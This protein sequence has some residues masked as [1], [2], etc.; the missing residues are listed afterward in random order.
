VELVAAVDLRG[1]GRDLAGG[2][3]ANGIAQGVDIRAEIE[4][5]GVHGG[6]SG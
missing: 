3:L 1:D 2:E 4:V 5:Q 6:Q